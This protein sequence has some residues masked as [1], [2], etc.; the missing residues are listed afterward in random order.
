MTDSI[1][2]IKEYTNKTK[3]KVGM[4]GFHPQRKEHIDADPHDP[5]NKRFAQWEEE[6]ERDLDNRFTP[7]SPDEKRAVCGLVYLNT[8]KTMQATFYRE[9]KL[10]VDG[11]VRLIGNMHA[12]LRKRDPQ[13]YRHMYIWIQIYL[14][15]EFDRVSE[16]STPEKLTRTEDIDS[17][18]KLVDK[19]IAQIFGVAEDMKAGEIEPNKQYQFA[20]RANRI[21]E[22]T[23]KLRALIEEKASESPE[24]TPPNETETDT[25]PRYS[26]TPGLYSPHY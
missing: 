15:R 26:P 10:G 3:L 7:L 22:K 6:E 1:E 20:I 14:K 4:L 17:T 21:I 12:A 23:E 16:K 13:T 24:S 5:E 11:L 9:I 18:L 19:Q 2:V 25:H 8:R